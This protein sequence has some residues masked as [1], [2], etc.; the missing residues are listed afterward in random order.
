MDDFIPLAAL[1]ITSFNTQEVY[2][3]TTERVTVLCINPRINSN[4]FC[5]HNTS[6]DSVLHKICDR[7][8]NKKEPNLLI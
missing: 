3:L 1:S 7:N 8:C 4:H 2:V 6:T 5:T